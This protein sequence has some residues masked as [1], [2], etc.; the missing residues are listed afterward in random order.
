MFTGVLGGAGKVIKKLANRNKQ[1]DVAN[2][3]IDRWIDKVAEKFRSRSGWTPE[4]FEIQRGMTG[5]RAADTNVARTLSRE[6]EVDIDKLFPP[7]KTM[8]D[9]QPLTKHR[10][11]I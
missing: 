5:A 6:L 11:K 3:G 2:S 9:K 1:L 10:K 8:F 7:M 4:G